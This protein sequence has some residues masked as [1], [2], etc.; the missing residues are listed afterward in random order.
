MG[1]FDQWLI[2]AF[3]HSVIYITVQALVSS[4]FCDLTAKN[5]YISETI[6]L[7]AGN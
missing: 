4:Q 6:F 7:G 2:A 5:E 3:M 1:Y